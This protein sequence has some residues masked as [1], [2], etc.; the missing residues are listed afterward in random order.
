MI[1]I[2]LS[3]LRYGIFPGAVHINRPY[4][5]HQIFHTMGSVVGVGVIILVLKGITLATARARASLGRS[6]L[7]GDFTTIL[8]S[9]NFRCPPYNVIIITTTMT[10]MIT[11]MI[12]I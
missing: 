11:I 7:Y 9:S 8:P 5:A 2:P 12:I 3:R 6:A 4:A 1:I 10:I